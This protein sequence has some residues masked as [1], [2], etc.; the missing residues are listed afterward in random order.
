MLDGRPSRT[1]WAAAVHR[2]THQV[3]E[4]GRIFTDPVAVAMTGLSVEQLRAG[5]EEHPRALG[6]RTFLACRHAFAHDTLAAEASRGT[7]QVVVLGAG[8]DTT[9][10]RPWALDPPLRVFEVDHPATQA[11]KRARTQEAGIVATTLLVHVPV[12][13]ETED[14]LVEL[15]RGGFSDG[16]PTVVLWLGVVPY[17]TRQAV[18]ATLSALGRLPGRVDLVLDYGE[19]LAEEDPG[20]PAPAHRRTGAPARACRT[21]R[22][23]RRTPAH[24]L[25]AR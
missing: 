12:D 15:A 14:F 2:A 21:A 10:Y 7:R 6:M 23:D 22:P 11:W 9:A 1:A 19:P 20:S 8:L 18:E 17:L 24:L 5:A 16:E 3:V 25:R 4:N 13:F